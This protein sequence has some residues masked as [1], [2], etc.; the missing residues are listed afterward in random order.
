[1]TKN[2]AFNNGR[3]PHL[4]G[5]QAK[6]KFPSPLKHI[7]NL[8]IHL[9]YEVIFEVVSGFLKLNLALKYSNV[10]VCCYCKLSMHG[11]FSN[12]A[13]DTTLGADGPSRVAIRLEAEVKTMAAFAGFLPSN[14]SHQK[15]LNITFYLFLFFFSK[16]EMNEA[17]HGSRRDFVRKYLHNDHEASTASMRCP[18]SRRLTFLDLRIHRSTNIPESLFFCLMFCEW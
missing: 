18:R 12:H 6:H 9:Y 14:G 1:V 13:N 15:T 17:Q 8:H 7:G 16:G 5:N 11:S 10:T 2:A 3:I 4:P